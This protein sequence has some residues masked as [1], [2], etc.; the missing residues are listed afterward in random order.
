MA[1]RYQVEDEQDDGDG[2]ENMA[3]EEI[4]ALAILQAIDT[5]DPRGEGS[6]CL[7]ALQHRWIEYDGARG[8]GR[9]C[10][11]CFTCQDSR[12][13]WAWRIQPPL[14]P[15]E[16]VK[17]TI[18]LKLWQNELARCTA[19]GCIAGGEHE[20]IDVKDTQLRLNCAGK[21]CQKCGVVNN[22]SGK[23]MLRPM[24]FNIFGPP[25]VPTYRG[26]HHPVWRKEK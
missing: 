7:A 8:T 26:G 20:W 18:I 14:P 9:T 19:G 11:H 22:E 15:G 1:H 16:E 5:T 17:A 6:H 23:M 21:C 4:E 12:G 2:D 10:E 24:L 3:P 13:E 25:T